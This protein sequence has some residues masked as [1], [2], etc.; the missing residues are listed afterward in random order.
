[1]GS[2]NETARMSDEK[3]ARR[4]ECLTSLIWVRIT[5]KRR[6]GNDE[7]VSIVNCVGKLL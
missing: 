3:E 1:M 4:H 5:K 6:I 2:S 7:F